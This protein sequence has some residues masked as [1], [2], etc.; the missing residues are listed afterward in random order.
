MPRGGF[1]DKMHEGLA[2]REAAAYQDGLSILDS[3]LPDNDN[4][5]EQDATQWERRL[6]LITNSLVSLEDRKMSI[7]QKMSH[8][9][10]IKGRQHYLFLERE[11]QAAGFDVYVFENKFPDGYGDYYTRDPLDISGN[12]GGYTIQHGDPTP[13][14]GD[15]QHGG[16]Y[17]NLIANH[18]DEQIDWLFNTGPNLRSTFYIGGTPLGTFA[19]VDEER[20]NEF[21]QLILR[22][23]PTHM[24]GFL[25]INY[26]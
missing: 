26:V 18:I 19:D 24:V 16:A 3:A 11:L 6:G 13:Q 5:T 17:Q 7:L 8:P 14:H 23:K 10:E 15:V 20:K 1:F 9:G 25:L 12:V 4:F 22:V 21:R 2:I